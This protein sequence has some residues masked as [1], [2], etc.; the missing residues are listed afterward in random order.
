MSNTAATSSWNPSE[1]NRTVKNS[2]PAAPFMDS[3][4]QELVNSIDQREYVNAVVLDVNGNAL[5]FKLEGESQPAEQ[6]HMIEATINELED[7]LTAVKNALLQQTGY[8]TSNWHYIGTFLRN[9]NQ[10]E[11]VGHIFVAQAA[12]KSAEPDLLPNDDGQP[13]W[14]PI[15]ELK[16]GLLDGR[17]HSFRYALNAALALL[18]L[19]Y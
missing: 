4:K 16:Y 2:L 6:W 10:E 17:I 9:E 14:I 13:R 18:M 15:E 12:R 1:K 19:S 5:V 7:P 8:S 3:Q 11:G